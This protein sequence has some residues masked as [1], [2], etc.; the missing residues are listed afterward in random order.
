MHAE[1]KYLQTQTRLLQTIRGR[2]RKKI[3]RGGP[4]STFCKMK[5]IHSKMY[6]TKN[7]Q[8][9][10][11]SKRWGPDPWSPPPSLHHAAPG[12]LTFL[13]LRIVCHKDSSSLWLH[14]KF[15]CTSEYSDL[16]GH[17]LIKLNIAIRCSLK[18]YNNLVAVHKLARFI[19]F[20]RSDLIAKQI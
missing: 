4:E 2:S 13:L 5:G 18:P 11:W 10:A 6:S 17:G 20:Y 1:E 12:L 14:V 3:L 9:K 16:Q 15:L 7:L 8:R 19:M